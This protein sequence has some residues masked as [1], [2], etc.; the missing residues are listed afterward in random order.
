M[1]IIEVDRGNG[2][3][4]AGY[5]PLCE[6]LGSMPVCAAHQEQVGTVLSCDWRNLRV[7]I[8]DV[9]SCRVPV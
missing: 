5:P 9:K 2:P 7:H 8:A 3:Q 6:R 1:K 4:P